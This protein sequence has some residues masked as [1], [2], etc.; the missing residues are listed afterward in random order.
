MERSLPS[1]TLEPTA[2]AIDEARAPTPT[3]V[4]DVEPEAPRTPISSALARSLAAA[5]E[6]E[7]PGRFFLRVVDARTDGPI[8]GA[9]VNLSE[10]RVESLALLQEAG[11]ATTRDVLDAQEDLLS[12]QN[13]VTE[14][15]VDHY[16]AR[17]DL[18]LAMET[19][20]ASDMSYLLAN[21]QQIPQNP[22]TTD[23][24]AAEPKGQGE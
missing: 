12:A 9:H 21:P 14:A 7:F 8:A 13:A 3:P 4:R 20:P 15:L 11:Q 2:A 1:E 16:Y 5:D 19:L 24:V 6:P 10:R 17:L 23:I 22:E 18:T